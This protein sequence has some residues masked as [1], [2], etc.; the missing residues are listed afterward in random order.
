MR[1]SSAAH[2]IPMLVQ[3]DESNVPLSEEVISQ[4]EGEL[5]PLCHMTGLIPRLAG[6]HKSKSML[7]Q[8]V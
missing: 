4:L 7:V 2:A 3:V 8:V 1:A 6:I 5:E